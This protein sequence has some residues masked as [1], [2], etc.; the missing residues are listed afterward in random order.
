MTN[1]EAKTVVKVEELTKT[2]KIPTESSSGLKQK[3]I[4]T[5]KGK[6]GYREFT[7][8]KDISFEV[9]EGDFFGIVGRNGSGKST[10]LKSIANIYNPTS[11]AA[12]VTGRL[13]PFIELG[14]GFNPELTGR[15]NVYLNGALLGF[16]HAQMEA[17]YDDIVSFA[18]IGDF[19]EEK[20]KN[21]SSGMQVRL[22][23][24][25]AI[26][27]EGDILLLDE[28]LAVGDEAFQKKCFDYFEQLR[29]EKRTVILVT[30]DMGSVK[31]FCTKAILIENGRIKMSG[32]PDDIA[33]QYTLDNLSAHDGEEEHTEKRMS[34]SGNITS[35]RVVSK[36]PHVLGRDGILE[37]D[38]EYEYHGDISDVY[39]G[40][41]LLYRNIPIIE[42]D[43]IGV[44]PT[45][46][47]GKKR[48]YSYRL[49]L[50][51]F[52]EGD[53]AVSAAL[54]GIHEKN[55]IAFTTNE[56]NFS[57]AIR[58]DGKDIGGLLVKR[59]EWV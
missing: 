52:T 33:N 4:N 57:F 35:I 20:L 36:S 38:V 44:K 16:S 42:Q 8:L 53:F 59:G 56:G 5:M 34:V 27:A 19:M 11:G 32:T 54:L 23:F 30:H 9:K 1:Q 41:G 50:D 24:S 28:V 48:A 14:V 31:R 17:M 58:G 29:E 51:R 49:P 46:D 13:V 55:L 7:P 21:Y 25:I 39:L 43:T 45:K 18:E 2:F 6:K 12:H 26:K 47:D 37:F 15:E 10:L 22:A 3:I 40:I